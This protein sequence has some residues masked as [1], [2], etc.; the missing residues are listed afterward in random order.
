MAQ[1]RNSVDGAGILKSAKVNGWISEPSSVGSFSPKMCAGAMVLEQV[2]M[3][4]KHQYHL[5]TH[6]L[7]GSMSLFRDVSFEMLPHR[8]K[9]KG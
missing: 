9:S 5:K 1:V 2:L 6:Q 7:L 4:K 8:V 3:E